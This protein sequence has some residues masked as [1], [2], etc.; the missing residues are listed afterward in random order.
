MVDDM[1]LR[2][3]VALSSGGAAGL[4]HIG[5]LEELERG[6]ITVECVAGTSA[7]AMVGAAFAAGQLEE[8][9]DRMLAW[10]S[11][12]R[13]A[14][15]DPIWPRRGFLGGRRAMDLLGSC[16]SGDIEAMPLRYAAVAADLDSGQRVTLRS[17]DVC[18]AIRASIAIPGM[19]TPQLRDGRLLVD[20]AL[21]DP[22][23]VASTRELG[24]TFVIASS[25]IGS[26][27]TALTTRCFAKRPR[28]TLERLLAYVR[29]VGGAT[30]GAAVE[31]VSSAPGVESICAAGND[32]LAEILYK[33]SAVVQTT[34]A[35]ARLQAEPPDFLIAP[36]AYDIGLFEVWRASEAIEAGRAATRA[37]LPELLAALEQAS[38][39]MTPW[40]WSWS[41]AGTEAAA[42]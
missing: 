10:Q 15:C 7:G 29:G 18:E 13:L 23:P 27:R 33:A 5:V 19:L 1:T 9:R 42:A 11:R 38:P 14:L 28:P 36:P 20:G 4:A 22:V 25:V 21:V 30:H 16:A 34:I 3:G 35:A 32:G 12:R 40:W 41:G 6:G 24:A 17:G 26:P 2:V 31:P 37:A 8:F 39:R